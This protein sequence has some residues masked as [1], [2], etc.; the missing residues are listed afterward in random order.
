MSIQLGNRKSI[1]TRTIPNQTICALRRR[2]LRIGTSSFYGPPATMTKEQLVA[3]AK[4]LGASMVLIH[5][6]YKDTL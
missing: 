4:K 1:L 3:E 6:Q 5:S 2:Y